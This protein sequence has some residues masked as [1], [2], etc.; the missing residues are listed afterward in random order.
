MFSTFDNSYNKN[1]KKPHKNMCYDRSIMLTNRIML[2][3]IDFIAFFLY[4]GNLN[5]NNIN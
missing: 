5:L 1:N 3:M 2:V 4:L